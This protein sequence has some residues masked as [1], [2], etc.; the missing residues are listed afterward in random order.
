MPTLNGNGNGPGNVVL[1]NP[2]AFQDKIVAVNITQ[3]YDDKKHMIQQRPWGTLIQCTQRAWPLSASQKQ[4]IEGALQKGETV[5]VLAYRTDS[6]SGLPLNDSRKIEAVFQL[7]PIDGLSDSKVTH[8]PSNPQPR[9]NFQLEFAPDKIEK[10]Y[11]GKYITLNTAQVGFPQ[12]F[13]WPSSQ[14]NQPQNSQPQNSQPQN[15]QPQNNQTQNN[16]NS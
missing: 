11:L 13:G 9:T 10:K 14:N 4:D 6:S 5:Y 15:N 3:S 1:L 2:S 8:N 12:L 16:T 7:H